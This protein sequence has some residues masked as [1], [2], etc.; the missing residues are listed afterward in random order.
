MICSQV[1]LFI[2]LPILMCLLSVIF[3][4]LSGWIVSGNDVGWASAICQLSGRSHFHPPRLQS[5]T[6]VVLGILHDDIMLPM[7]R[8]CSESTNESGGLWVG[9]HQQQP[10]GE[11][12]QQT[13]EKITGSGNT[14]LLF[15]IFCLSTSLSDDQIDRQRALTSLPYGVQ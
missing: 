12:E 9:N 7:I 6:E 4:D 14:R 8:C 3:I 13:F 1:M 2:N 10:C 5:M 15:S 11:K